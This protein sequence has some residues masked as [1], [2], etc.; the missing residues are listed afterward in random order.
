MTPLQLH[1]LIHYHYAVDDYPE[2]AYSVMQAL[3]Y[4]VKH[5]YLN[6]TWGRKAV[7]KPTPKLHAF[8]NALCRVQEPVQ[9]QSWCVPKELANDVS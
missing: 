8:V 1:I 9:V 7:Y 3:D 5:G 4:F 2:S 6:A